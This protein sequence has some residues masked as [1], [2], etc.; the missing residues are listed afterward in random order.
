MLHH[1]IKNQENQYGIGD[2]WNIYR[3]SYVSFDIVKKQRNRMLSVP[4]MR[5]DNVK[6]RCVLKDTLFII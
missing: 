2:L 3:V 6:I 4:N 1:A 5:S